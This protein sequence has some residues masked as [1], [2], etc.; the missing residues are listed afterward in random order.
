[1]LESRPVPT[2]RFVVAEVGGTVVAAAAARLRGARWPTRSGA[3][4]HLL[5]LLELRAKQLAP[6]ARRTPVGAPRRG[7]RLGPRV[8]VSRRRPR[9]AR[10]E[11]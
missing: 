1:M 6:V 8:G 5:P 9:A 4:A 7:A 10:R 2:G 3:T 11:R